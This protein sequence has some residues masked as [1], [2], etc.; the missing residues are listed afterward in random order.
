MRAVILLTLGLGIGFFVGEHWLHLSWIAAEWRLLLGF[1]LSVSL[2][3]TR[4]H[5]LGRQQPDGPLG[6]LPLVSTVLRLLL[7]FVFLGVLLRRGV[8]DKMTFLATFLV[9]YICYVG[10]EIGASQRKLHRDS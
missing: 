4:L 1:F 7:T 8:A 10:F 2:V 5:L 9:L 6:L 3:T